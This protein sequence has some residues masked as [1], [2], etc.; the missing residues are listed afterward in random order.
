MRISLSVPLYFLILFQSIFV[1]L[2]FIY[3]LYIGTHWGFGERIVLLMVS[4]G[5]YLLLILSS[6]SLYLKKKWG[7]WLTVLVYGK[8]FLAKSI[9][10]LLKL[11]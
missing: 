8:L 10:L 4:D 3:Y 11:G 9:A 7:W 5:V 1:S 2:Y 6:I